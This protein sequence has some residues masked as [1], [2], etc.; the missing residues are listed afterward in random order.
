[1]G[2]AVRKKRAK[3]VL[4]IVAVLVVLGVR[5]ASQH[6]RVAELLMTFSDKDAKP[7]VTDERITFDARDGEKIAARVYRPAGIANPPVVDPRA[8]A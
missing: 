7:N 4:F 5:P 1:M 6:A 3:I 8:T 2:N